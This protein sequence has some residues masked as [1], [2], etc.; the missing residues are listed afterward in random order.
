MA[1]KVPGHQLVEGAAAFADPR[2]MLDDCMVF[3]RERLS[4]EGSVAGDGHAMCSCGARGPHT[5]SARERRKWQRDHRDEVLAEM[6]A[7][8]SA[9]A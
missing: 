7:K 5:G 6:K 2:C 3:Y 8:E 1:L 9:A 4:P